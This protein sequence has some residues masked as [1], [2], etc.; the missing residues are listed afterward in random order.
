MEVVPLKDKLLVAENERKKETA[1]GIIIETSTTLLDTAS[2]KV[3]A[4]GPEVKNIAVGDSIY[5]NWGKTSLVKIDGAQ[6][7]LVAE[8][9]VLAIIR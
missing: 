2:G 3:L 4:I 1:S 7:V 8:E 9:D 5:L 6:R